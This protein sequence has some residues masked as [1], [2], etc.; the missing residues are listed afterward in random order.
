M[1]GS[2]SFEYSSNALGGEYTSE[3]KFVEEGVYVCWVF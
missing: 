2:N 1:T 3:V